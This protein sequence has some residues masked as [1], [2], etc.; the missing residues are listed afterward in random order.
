MT[1][2][3]AFFFL[4]MPDYLSYITSTTHTRCWVPS[5]SPLS[6]SELQLDE[7][8]RN[9]AV[10]GRRGSEVADGGA[11]RRR[12]REMLCKDGNGHL[13]PSTDGNK[14]KTQR[15]NIGWAQD[16]QDLRTIGWSPWNIEDLFRFTLKYLDFPRPL[17]SLVLDVFTSRDGLRIL[18]QQHSL[19]TSS[20]SRRV[21]LCS[22]SMLAEHSVRRR[23]VCVC[24]FGGVRVH[25]MLFNRTFHENVALSHTPTPTHAHT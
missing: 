5:L 9:S 2:V 21:R 3:H 12:K 8:L 1:L 11:E 22:V 13:S 7:R 10:I 24:V 20:D 19:G 6:H 23:C 25:V 15:K 4:S 18:L 17:F 14:K 16:K